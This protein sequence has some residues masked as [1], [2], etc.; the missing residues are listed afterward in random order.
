MAMRKKG[1][2]RPGFPF[3]SGWCNVTPMQNK[4]EL[5]A[6]AGSVDAGYAALHYGADSI[7]L[8]LKQFSARADAANF[9]PEELDAI[10]AY[11]HSLQ[12]GRKV[13]VTV[14]TL[15]LQD[16]LAGLIEQLGTLADIG[17]DALII[18][19]LGVLRIAKKH[20]PELRLHGSTQ[21]AVHNRAGVEALKDLGFAR[22]TLAR[23]LTLDEIREVVEQVPGIETEIFVHGALCYSY[24]GLCLFSSHR[25]GRS[26]NRGRC[27]YL[28]RD[29]FSVQGS[30]LGVG[31]SAFDVPADLSA[32]AFAKA[33]G[34][35]LFSMKDLA[36]PAEVAELGKAGVTSFKIEGRMKSPLYVAAT[37]NYY[38]KLIDGNASAAERKELEADIQTI[39]S[40]PWTELYTRSRAAKDVIDS[41]TVGHRGTPIGTVDMVL[42]KRVL[43]FRTN[44]AIEVHD[45]LQID[46]PG[47]AKPFGF[48]VDALRLAGEYKHTFEAPANTS[49]EVML[50]DE[51]PEIPRGATVYHASSQDVKQR[52][53]FDRP[54]PGAFRARRPLDVTIEIAP[55]K[56]VARAGA[57]VTMAG[58]FSP[59]KDVRK[60]E[61]AARNA[62]GKLGDTRFELG[63]LEIS[64]PGNLFVPV[65]QMNDL[66][67]RITSEVEKELADAL[68][69]RIQHIQGVV[70]A[71]SKLE[72]GNLKFAWSLKVD[73]I[74]HLKDFADEDWKDLDEVVVEI[75]EDPVDTLKTLLR[76]LP[77]DH[78]RLALP[79]ITRKWEEKEIADKIVELQ[80]AGWT[81]WEAA[82]VSGWNFLKLEPAFV[83]PSAGKPGNL[84]ADWSVYVTNS[85]AAKQVMDM[86]ASRFTLSPEDGRDNMEQLLAEFG[87]KATVIVYQD[88]PLF[89]SESC[90]RAT[91]EP[92]PGKAKCSFETT[93]LVSSH[94]DDVI[95]VNRDCRTILISKE[96]FCLGARLRD[97]DEAGAS[98]LRADFI[99]RPYKPSEV[100]E[101][102]RALRDGRNPPRGHIGNFDRG[103][104]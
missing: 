82:N 95:A 54:K 35:F 62:F 44:R 1:D 46:I 2:F 91:T 84:A 78:V 94:G 20:F 47:E 55:D 60:T 64:N 65:S 24:S 25:L 85:E 93:E 63:R 23:E 19:D 57:E 5:M 72:I 49:V 100:V 41:D 96:P 73:R 52:Y 102:W 40:R 88:T 11:A 50:P 33:E 38:R 53:P 90:V 48:P 26:G 76:Q 70:S 28:C 30:T 66:R 10:T 15:V 12:P 98:S 99:N 14:N 81:K 18:Q 77:R 43:R 75:A 89:I 51:H 68:S 31:R 6:P 21:M 58:T 3:P 7:Y 16:E 101:L 27:A 42:D 80:R 92:C 61:E 22:A 86:G 103:L 39:F 83:E 45:G 34:R 17:V 32:V 87:A 8:G 59:A 9:T 67:R 74:N 29:A 69:H 36:L 97:L 4:P 13:F 37:T 56:L 79:M 104:Q 71:H